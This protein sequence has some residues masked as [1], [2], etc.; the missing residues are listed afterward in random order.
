M[1]IRRT[2]REKNQSRKVFKFFVLLRKA[3]G[4][5]G[6]KKP[7]L[8]ERLLV[9]KRIQTLCIWTIEKKCFEGI[10]GSGH[11]LP[12]AGPDHE[13]G[14]SLEGISCEERMLSSYL[15]TRDAKEIASLLFFLPWSS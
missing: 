9:L 2:R 7:W 1:L 12:I 15:C 5:L 8:L 4:K 13:R 3:E 14:A 6:L 11:T 10:S